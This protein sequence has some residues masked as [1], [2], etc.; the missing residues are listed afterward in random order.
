MVP[1]PPPPPPGV[2]MPSPGRGGG[3]GGSA[4]G[5]WLLWLVLGLFAGLGYGL[6]QRLLDLQPGDDGLGGHQPFSVKAFPGSGLEALRRSQRGTARS[7]PADLDALAA[8]QRRRTDAEELQR[9]QADMERRQ[10]EELKEREVEQDRL[11]LEELQRTPDPAP[12]PALDAPLPELAEP[13]PAQP[14][15]EPGGEDPTL[16]P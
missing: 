10:Q 16:R 4:A 12:E 5:G 2:A 15:A 3:A 9:R 7:L 11:R 13:P 1:A 6:T 14:P 8:E